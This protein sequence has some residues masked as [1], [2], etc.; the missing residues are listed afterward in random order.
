MKTAAPNS[1]PYNDP[2][3]WGSTRT[4]QLMGGTAALGG[5]LALLAILNDQIRSNRR[6]S[7]A[8]SGKV[9][10]DTISISPLAKGA[11]VTE[12]LGGMGVGAGAYWLVQKAYQEMRRK[13]LA[14]E[15]ADEEKGYTNN[16]IE[17]VAT[18][19]AT[20]GIPT[21]SG[22]ELLA[23]IPKDLM[24]L[25]ALAAGAGTYGLLEHTWPKVSEKGEV[26]KPKK[27]VVK[28]YG[29]IMADGPGDGPLAQM[30]KERGSKMVGRTLK[31]EEQAAPAEQAPASR[32]SWMGHV[33]PKA[34]SLVCPVGKDDAHCAAAMMT[35]LLAEQP[36]LKLAHSGLV[37]LI[38]AHLSD[39]AKAETLVKEA[40][41]LTAIELS[42]GEDSRYYELNPM[43]KRAACWQAFASPV[44]GPCLATL[45]VAELEEFNPDL[46]KRARV[47]NNDPFYGTIAMK[48]AALTWQA[49][50][51]LTE[52]SGSLVKSAAAASMAGEMRRQMGTLGISD[53]KDVDGSM[54]DADDAYSDES[55]P[56]DEFMAGKK[57][58]ENKKK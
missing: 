4:E 14:A 20:G 21:P 47:V 15:I 10:E 43:D 3:Q 52:E 51:L 30:D 53:S 5:G 24:W 11:T 46:S 37:S 2:T 35:F 27:I 57:K 16:L 13:Q 9:L 22:W 25:P 6:K 18:K 42:K 34:A 19:Q 31:A 55:D 45:A 8:S 36:A 7:R 40:G 48:I 23:N 1:I 44:L 49:E 26:G 33:L 41:L 17:S 54:D 38:G 50:I 28:G 29:T 56:I 58:D 12:Y 32:P 39:P